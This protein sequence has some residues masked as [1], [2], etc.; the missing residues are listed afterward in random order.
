MLLTG[1]AITQS[2]DVSTLLKRMEALYNQGKYEEAM[3][4]AERTLG[5]DHLSVAASLCNLGE[6]YRKQ[7]H[8]IDGIPLYERTAEF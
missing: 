1:P 5:L 4:L 3:P 8:Y 2:D 7:D 6:V